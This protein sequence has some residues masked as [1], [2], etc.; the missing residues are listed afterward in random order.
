[1]AIFSRRSQSLE[2]T[3]DVDIFNKETEGMSQGQIVIKRFFRHRGAMVSLIVLFSLIT[4]VFSTLGFKILGVGYGGWWKYKITDLPVLRTAGCSIE[5]PGCPSLSLLPGKGFGLGDHPFGQDDLGRDYFS[6][7]MRGAERSIEVMVV[8]GLVAGAFGIIIGAIAGFYRGWIDAILMRIN[9]FIITIPIIVLGGV[10][11][12]HFGNKGILFLAFFLG[13]LSWGGL[14]RLVRGE[15]L[16]LRER[17]FVDAARVA[18]AS[19]RRIIFKHILPNAIGVIIVNVTLVMSGAILLESA[20]SYLG[21]GVVAPDVSLGLL[22]SQYQDS[23]TTRPWLFWYPGL[24]IIIIALCVNFIGD[25]L[26]DAFDPRQRRRIS[27]RV[28][29]AERQMAVKK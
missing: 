8:I 6:L 1:M 22:I 19:N 15:F 29:N 20:L 5:L 13:V 21:L 9:D 12:Y 25:G 16:T 23:F 10:I 18:G 4:F 2:E 27:R 26:R 17:E 14:S 7:V 24:L 3:T 28:R 11:S